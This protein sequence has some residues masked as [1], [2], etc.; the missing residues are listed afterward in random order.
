VLTTRIRPRATLAAALV[1]VPVLS[2]LLPVPAPLT[3]A[4]LVLALATELAVLRSRLSR[5]VAQTRP[6]GSART[7]T[8]TDAS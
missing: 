1:L 3:A 6:S 4:A 8:G 7:S 2:L 5:A